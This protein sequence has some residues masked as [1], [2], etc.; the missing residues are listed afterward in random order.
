VKFEGCSG[1]VGG[2]AHGIGLRLSKLVKLGP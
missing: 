2:P 1:D